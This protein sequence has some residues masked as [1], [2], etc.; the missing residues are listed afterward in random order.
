MFDCLLTEGSK[1]L[2]RAGLALLKLHEPSLVSTGKGSLK[3]GQVLKWR[4]ARTYDA[5][6]LMKVR[7]GIYARRS[8]LGGTA[9]TVRAGRCGPALGGDCYARLWTPQC[10]CALL[11]EMFT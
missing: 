2:H 3:L 7:P 8:W 11:A 4:V 9:W 5:E 10:A 1:S 6:Q